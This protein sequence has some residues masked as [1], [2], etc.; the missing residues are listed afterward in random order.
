MTRPPDVVFRDPYRNAEGEA[1]RDGLRRSV[2]LED[3]V[4]DLKP[5]DWVRMIFGKVHEVEFVFIDRG[6]FVAADGIDCHNVTD[7]IEVRSS[8]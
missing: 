7:I 4:R 8:S 2:A 6:V 1:L 5:G 3:R